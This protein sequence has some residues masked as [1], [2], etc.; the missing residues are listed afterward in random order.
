MLLVRTGI[1]QDSH[2]FLPEDSSKPCIL[3]GIIFDDTPG[4]D[5]QSDGDVVFHALCNA[6]LSLGAPSILG[7]RNEL[8]HKDGITDSA[9][10]LQKALKALQN[11]TITHVAISIEAKIPKIQ[12]K[13]HE[14]RQKIA[15]IMGLSTNQIGLT[16]ITGKG[17]S[18]F[19]CGDGIQCT[20]II[21]TQSEK[22]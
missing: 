18:D 4:L 1:G 9:F 21:T 6:L 7:E 5:A 10:Y 3:G 20:A 15:D 2:R 8:L 12:P 22:A 14:M 11:Q 17:L 13:I 19:G 16:A